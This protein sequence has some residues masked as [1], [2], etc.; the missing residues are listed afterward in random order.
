MKRT[1]TRIYVTQMDT[2]PSIRIFDR[3]LVAALAGS[4]VEKI[5]RLVLRRSVP[6]VEY[7]RDN[8]IGVDGNGAPAT[9]R[10]LDAGA[11][12]LTAT[13]VRAAITFEQSFGADIGLIITAID[14]YAGEFIE[15]TR[16]AELGGDIWFAIAID[17]DAGEVFASGGPADLVALRIAAT[18]TDSPAVAMMV[19]LRPLVRAVLDV[20]EASGAPAAIVP[21]DFIVGDQA[22]RKAA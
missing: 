17:G 6:L 9:G 10:T 7:I 21:P 3:S 12:A 5:V 18:M 14:M 13:A 4:S 15:A 1:D 2:T 19:H 16:R 22:G 11:S 20:L 8:A